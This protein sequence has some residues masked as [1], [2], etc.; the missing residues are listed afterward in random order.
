MIFT[1]STNKNIIVTLNESQISYC[2]KIAEVRQ[3][4]G[5]WKT[6]YGNGILNTPEDPWTTERVGMFGEYSWHLL[7]RLPID[8]RKLME[9]DKWD[10]FLEGNKFD[11][12]TKKEDTD[13]VY[14]ECKFYIRAVNNYGKTLSLTSD[15][16][17]FATLLYH[18]GKT[19]KKDRK[20]NFYRSHEKAKEVVIC[21]NGFISNKKILK[22]NRIGTALSKKCTHKNYYLKEEEITKVSELL[23]KYKQLYPQGVI[24][25]F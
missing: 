7:T 16:Y 18:N 11:V 21:L 6:E 3:K 2:N 24:L 25:H 5:I 14:E 13:N 17:V 1:L 9:G 15:Y 23:S 12:K 19:I 20:G 22:I 8:E 10:F 4:M